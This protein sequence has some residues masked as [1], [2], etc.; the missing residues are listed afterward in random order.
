VSEESKYGVMTGAIDRFVPSRNTLRF[1]LN[2][3]GFQLMR[4]RVCI[5]NTFKRDTVRRCLTQQT[6]CLF[7][8]HIS[9]DVSIK[10]S[11]C[12][13]QSEVHRCVDIVSQN[14]NTKPIKSYQFINI[15]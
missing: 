13:Y 8:I 3:N 7:D 10:R 4:G 11:L 14:M 2:V 1:C 9:P 5:V 6:Q 15:S 12:V